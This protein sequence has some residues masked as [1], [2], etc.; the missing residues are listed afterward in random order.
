MVGQVVMDPE[1]IEGITKDLY[2]ETARRFRTTWSAVARS[3]CTAIARCWD[4]EAGRERFGQVAGHPWANRPAPSAFV[5]AIANHI[6]HI[7]R[8]GA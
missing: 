1:R 3:S 4:C 7:Y 5:T 8:P 2:R 6:T